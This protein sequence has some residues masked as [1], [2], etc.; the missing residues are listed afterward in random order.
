MEATQEQDNGIIHFERFLRRWTKITWVD[1]FHEI[2]WL[3]GSSYRVLE[4]N[5]ERFSATTMIDGEDFD[6]QNLTFKGQHVYPHYTKSV[7]W[8]DNW[9][10]GPY[11]YH[12]QELVDVFVRLR[13]VEVGA[14]GEERVRQRTCVR[15]YQAPC[16]WE[17][18]PCSQL[19]QP[20][21]S[22]RRNIHGN[23]VLDF[24]EFRT[25]HGK[26]SNL[27]V[28][29]HISAVA[30]DFSFVCFEVL[31]ACQEAHFVLSFRTNVVPSYR[32]VLRIDDFLQ[33]EKECIGYEDFD[34]ELY[35]EKQQYFFITNGHFGS[36][37]GQKVIVQWPD[38]PLDYRL[39]NPK[40]L[41]HKQESFC[42]L[43]KADSPFCLN[44][45]RRS[46]PTKPQ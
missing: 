1:N 43:E 31:R 16:S 24:D 12:F 23:W 37:L 13:E 18:M 5:D 29:R 41:S 28:T 17:P 4:L 20:I 35:M 45:K 25:Y 11:Q 9:D 15:R 6:A 21:G 39:E 27:T 3:A 32:E 42:A 22:P 38:G 10:S 44:K 40:P 7:G 26:N 2:D 34:G 8:R 33:I 36:S 46:S 19:T 14:N 30:L